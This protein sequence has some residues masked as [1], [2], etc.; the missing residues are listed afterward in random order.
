MAAGLAALSV[1]AQALSMNHAR[2][3]AAGCTSCHG[4]ERTGGL[5]ALAGRSKQEIVERMKQFRSGA[6]PS[7]LMGQLAKG[8]SDG[9][10]DLIAAFFAAQR[11]GETPP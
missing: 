10:I 9:E 6:R 8:Y 5:P 1:H 3:L 7:T 11:A 4:P 2:N